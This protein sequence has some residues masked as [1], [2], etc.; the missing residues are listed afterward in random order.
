VF[1]QSLEQ[2]GIDATAESFT[3]ID[4]DDRDQKVV[5]FTQLRIF[6]NIDDLRPE[7]VRVQDLLGDVAEMTS[8]PR[9]DNDIPLGHDDRLSDAREVNRREGNVAMRLFVRRQEQSSLPAV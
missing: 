9:I 7:T 2:R 1:D 6:I 4:D 5:P 3:A 8:L